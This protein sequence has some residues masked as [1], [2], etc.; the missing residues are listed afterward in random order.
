MAWTRRCW[1]GEWR[2]RL[3]FGAGEERHE[4]ADDGTWFGVEFGIMWVLK[5]LHS[6][7]MRAKLR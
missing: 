3:V 2:S 1:Q 4:V 7:E 6:R 5:C